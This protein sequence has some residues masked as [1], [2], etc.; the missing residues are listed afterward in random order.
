LNIR[1]RLAQQIQTKLIVDLWFR[2]LSNLPTLPVSLS[3]RA[4]DFSFV[5]HDRRGLNRSPISPRSRSGAR[6]T[7][8][9]DRVVRARHF[10][11]VDDP[12]APICARV[13]M[14]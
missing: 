14:S 9:E 10:F 12:L 11:F 8:H 1:Q 13:A 3:E 7:V 6:Q 4:G 2:A 5:D